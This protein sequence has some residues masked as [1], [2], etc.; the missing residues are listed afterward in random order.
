PKCLLPIPPGNLGRKK[1][2]RRGGRRA[3]TWIAVCLRGS[4]RAIPGR[5]GGRAGGRG[6]NGALRR[7]AD[8]VLGCAG[9]RARLCCIT[10]KIARQCPANRCAKIGIV[11]G[12][13]SIG[14]TVTLRLYELDDIRLAF[15]FI[16]ERP[17]IVQLPLPLIQALPLAVL[18]FPEISKPIRRKLAVSD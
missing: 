5:G 8:T 18:V 9:G 7:R 1:P 6:D 15:G 12:I 10:S 16:C 14:R 2:P 13:I 17:S 11:I 4:T 3:I